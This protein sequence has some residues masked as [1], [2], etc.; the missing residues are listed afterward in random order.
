MGRRKGRAPT[1][2]VLPTADEFECC[3][4]P[5]PGMDSGS[6]SPSP[7]TN[8]AEDSHHTHSTAR[9]TASSQACLA[10]TS[11][12][13]IPYVYMYM[14]VLHSCSQLP[15]IAFLHRN[16]FVLTMF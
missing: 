13:V 5:H 8:V 9:T 10:L 15:V 6:T 3:T 7:V 12:C 2:M 11:G 4:H 16:L 14:Y 1:E